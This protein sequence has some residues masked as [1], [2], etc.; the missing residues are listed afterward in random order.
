MK[1]YLSYIILLTTIEEISIL[2]Y[3]LN[4]FLEMSL[5][6]LIKK[7]FLIVNTV[8]LMEMKITN[9]CLKYLIK[10]MLLQKKQEKKIKVIIINQAKSYL[11]NQLENKNVN[12]LPEDTYLR[13]FHTRVR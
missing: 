12:F 3:Y 6:I 2:N 9:L 10:E 7:L 13:H 1:N 5:T 11:S 4:Y 8:L